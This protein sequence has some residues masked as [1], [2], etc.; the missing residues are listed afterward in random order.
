ML[1]PRAGSARLPLS[2]C[3]LSPVLEPSRTAS[4]YP[5]V[6]REE[7]L[8]QSF[9]SEI[10]PLGP[11][12]SGLYTV[13]PRT[14]VNDQGQILCCGFCGWTLEWLHGRLHCG[15]DRCRVLTANFTQP[16]VKIKEIAPGTEILR[17]HRAI[18][19]YV[20]APGI[21]ELTAAAQMRSLG[22]DVKLWP[23]FDAYDLHI[24]FADGEGWAVD[25]KDW[26][27]PSLLA[28]H[29]EPL[30][31]RQGRDWDRA[32]YAIPDVRVREN[33]SYLSLLHSTVRS[34]EFS[35]LTMSQLIEEARRH[36]EQL[37]AQH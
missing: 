21:Y 25:L 27:L 22:L 7:L 23:D 16:A 19:R 18:R 20:V 35:I 1:G 34:Q 32:F 14:V 17:V 37:D 8:Q 3:Y 9:D 13:A 31:G 11:N 5:V 28:P 2:A 6:T 15:D 36:K 10:E 30:P 24:S 12:L 4:K 26:R 33:P 29:L